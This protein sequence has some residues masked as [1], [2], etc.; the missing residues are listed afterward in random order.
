VFP[1]LI[2]KQWCIDKERVYLTGHSDGGTVALALALLEETRQIPSAI[3]PS[4][5]GF[6]GAEI[7]TF[8]CPAPLPVMILHSANDTLF[9][10]FGAEIAAWWA[11]CNECDPTPSDPVGNGCL[12]YLNC[13]NNVTT[14]YCEGN[15]A[16]P[17]WPALNESLIH[18]F[19]S[20][21]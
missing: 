9:P 21:G 5:A 20:A 2:A 1:G 19:S 11:A 3:A 15:G 4:A 13:A 6:T 17:T 8:S 18:F 14:L 16:H 10:G 12:A 7:A